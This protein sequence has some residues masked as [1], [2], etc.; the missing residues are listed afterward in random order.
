M[1][2]GL[3]WIE[4]YKASLGQ[5]PFH[6]PLEGFQTATAAHV[7]SAPAKAAEA[8]ADFEVVDDEE[9]AFLKV[10]TQVRCLLISHVPPVHFNH[11]CDG[12][13]QQLRTVGSDAGDLV[14]V[15][16]EVADLLHEPHEILFGGRIAMRPRRQTAVEIAAGKRGVVQSDE[17]EGAVV[18][19]VRKGMDAILIATESRNLCERSRGHS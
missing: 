4:R 16:P 5:D 3:R 9:A 10:R 1:E 11:V 19:D 14:D 15:R 13:L 18:R 2:T 8:T 17:R 6:V 12:I 7:C